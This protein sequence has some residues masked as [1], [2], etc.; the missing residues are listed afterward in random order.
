M[1]LFVNLLHGVKFGQSAAGA[2]QINKMV[3]AE[4]PRVKHTPCWLLKA[5]PPTPFTLR[6]VDFERFST[7]NFN[8][9]VMWS[10]R[11]RAS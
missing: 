8:V 1:F 2:G 5:S 6:M 10:S 4:C 7:I 11:R 3:E 9:I